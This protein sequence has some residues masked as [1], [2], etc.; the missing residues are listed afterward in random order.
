M[1]TDHESDYR[2]TYRQEDQMSRLI[3]VAVVSLLPLV[4]CGARTS[5]KTEQPPVSRGSTSSSVAAPTTTPAAD[6]TIEP[7]AIGRGD[8]SSWKL[9]VSQSTVRRGDLVTV[10]LAGQGGGGLLGGVLSTLEVKRNGRWR[11]IYTLFS[12][13][14]V[15]AAPTFLRADDPGL[16]SAVAIGIYGPVTIKVPPVDPGDYR[17]RRDFV[18]D[19]S[20]TV[21]IADRTVTLY[22][23]LHVIG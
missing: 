5:L 4:A 22:A 16:Y 20:T 17:M 23:L 21:A 7:D 1:V 19:G 12:P 18:A 11:T 15:G 9:A 3:G 14:Q 13:H 10:S 6:D 2:L 8:P